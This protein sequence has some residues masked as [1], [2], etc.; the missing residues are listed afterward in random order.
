MPEKN[1][2]TENTGKKAKKLRKEKPIYIDDG[3]TVVD[4]SGLD[5]ARRF[6]R[7]KDPSEKARP[8]VIEH[9]RTYFDSVRVML[10]PMLVVMLLIGVAFL[11]MWILMGGLQ[12]LF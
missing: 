3:S 10:L 12:S 5:E 11:A 2:K 1:K 8:K 6:R 9:L 7:K 4:M